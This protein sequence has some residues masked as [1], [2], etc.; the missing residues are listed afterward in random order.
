[1]KFKTL[2]LLLDIYAELVGTV[3]TAILILALGIMTVRPI[4]AVTTVATFHFREPS[5]VNHIEQVM[6]FPN[7]AALQ[8]PNTSRMLAPNGV[9]VVPFQQLFSIGTMAIQTTIPQSV[10]PSVFNIGGNNGNPLPSTDPTYPNSIQIGEAA[11]I[12]HVNDLVSLN[13]Q[14]STTNCLTNGGSYFISQ[15]YATAS[16]IRYSF[17]ATPG[18]ATITFGASPSCGGQP[19]WTTT[20]L[21]ANGTTNVITQPNHHRANRQ[22][23]KYTGTLPTGITSGTVYYI[24]NVSSA[25]AYQ[26]CTDVAGTSVVDIG[27]LTAGV[28]QVITDWTWT[29]QSG[30]TPGGSVNNPVA[31]DLSNSSYRQISNG[32]AAFR[33]GRFT[34]PTLT[35]SVAG[36]TLT[37]CVT[38]GTTETCTIPSHAFTMGDVITVNGTANCAANVGTVGGTTTNTV[39]FTIAGGCDTTANDSTLQV[40]NANLSYSPLQGIQLSSGEWVGAGGLLYSDNQLT[41]TGQYFHMNPTY[42]RKITPNNRSYS[43]YIA[44]AGPL[45]TIII[46]SYSTYLPQYLNGSSMPFSG[47]TASTSTYS[48]IFEIRAGDPGFRMTVAGGGMIYA[49]YPEMYSSWPAAKPDIRQFRFGGAAGGD[50][51]GTYIECGYVGLPITGA[52]NASPIRLTVVNHRLPNGGHITVTGVGGNT[53]ANVT[54]GTYSVVDADHIDLD[55]TTGNAPYTSGGTAKGQ[56]LSIDSGL[57]GTAT[58]DL[59]YAA[60][61]YI[62]TGCAPGSTRANMGVWNNNNAVG[63]T[64][65]WIFNAAA[66]S[67]APVLGLLAGRA[68]LASISSSLSYGGFYTANADFRTGTTG[69][70]IQ[71]ASGPPSGTE[72]A[73]VFNNTAGI[74]TRDF[75]IFTGTKADINALTDPYPISPLRIAQGRIAGVNLTKLAGIQLDFA[76]PAGGFKLPFMP[77][78][79]MDTICTN[80]RTN[81]PSGYTAQVN[82][83][84]GA[85]TSGVLA[86]CNGA[87]AAAIDTALAPFALI[88][89]TYINAMVNL[90]GIYTIGYNGSGINAALGNLSTLA[91]AIATSFITS[92]QAIVVKADAALLGGLAAVDQDV[93]PSEAACADS[94]GTANQALDMANA[95]NVAVLLFS[96]QPKIALFAP[97]VIARSVGLINVNFNTYGSPATS[98]HYNGSNNPTIQSL[99]AQKKLNGTSPTTYPRVARYVKFLSGILTPP[100]PRFG[101][102][103]TASTGRK[104]IGYGDGPGTA[105]LNLPGM[106]ATL[107][108]D[109]DTTISQEAIA[110]WFSQNNSSYLSYDEFYGPDW[111]A[112]NSTITSS[113]VN[114]A[115]RNFPGYFTVLRHNVGTAT[116]SAAYLLDGAYYS[117]HAHYDNGQLDAYFMHVPFCVDTDTNTYTPHPPSTLMHCGTIILDSALDSGKVWND[118]LATLSTPT[119]RW[120]TMAQTET[121]GFSKVAVA[122]STDTDSSGTVHTRNVILTNGNTSLPIYT[123]LDVFAGGSHATSSKTLTMLPLTKVATAIQTPDGSNTPAARAVD[124]SAFPSTFPSGGSAF[125]LPAGLNAFS[126]PGTIWAALG[127]GGNGID[128]DFYIYGSASMQYAIGNLKMTCTGNREDAE[129]YAASGNTEHFT[130]NQTRLLLHDTG[131]YSQFY[132][133]HYKNVTPSRTVT[134]I[135]GGIQVVTTSPV[136]TT[137][138]ITATQYTFTDGTVQCLASFDTASHA[139]FGMTISGGPQQVCQLS[140]TTFSWEISGM[141]GGTHSFEYLALSLFPNKAIGWDGSA[142]QVYHPGADS[143]TGV[144]D[145]YS[146]SFSTTPAVFYSVPIQGYAASGNMYVKFGSATDFVGSTTCSGQ[147]TVTLLSP[148][149]SQLETIC[150]GTSGPT[151]CGGQTTHAVPH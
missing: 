56:L 110:N 116:E 143:I 43:S 107:Y 37:Q 66:G 100:E 123:V 59:A 111:T 132:L 20:A 135:T 115:T 113:S 53:N 55:G 83:S 71:I 120:G 64:A 93:Y 77:D 145:V 26:I 103:S 51:Q 7:T 4:F 75:V 81:N 28:N 14:G 17:A 133:P 15:I 25:H 6:E 147:C 150:K 16:P 85:N 101:A 92:D 9:D 10:F 49:M 62:D 95:Q 27:D 21:I 109:I 91:F 86:I 126:Y 31:L 58:E 130:Q 12:L 76:D 99:L 24:C 35:Y 149:G 30:T 90:D 104:A 63:G 144:P 38:S 96:T 61:V 136:S 117:D 87:N 128:M 1:M 36:G 140:A 2:S 142:F 42:F 65:Q 118:D 137:E 148:V 125:S 78:A 29:F 45:K 68:S 94:C 79:D 82:R 114:L 40:H 67:S 3:T 70:G 47:S 19:L 151:V 119:F 73:P 124:C 106:G 102:A 34:N 52:S 39:S 72:T 13:S 89:L 108:Q 80:Y 5:G 69:L 8:N 134:A 60:N 33:V 146:Y 48:L 141:T 44:E 139:A 121:L 129:F 41:T 18:G 88:M 57:D 105:Y 112:I 11:G 22:P 122:R 50:H 23:V 98:T 131:P 97:T 46:A 74:T 32:L 127:T 54:N 84:T 138:T